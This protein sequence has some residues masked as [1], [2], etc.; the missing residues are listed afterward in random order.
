MG[1]E[2]DLADRLEDIPGIFNKLRSLP[3]AHRS[4]PI[5]L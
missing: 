3:Q 2:S 5:G 4:V 1:L